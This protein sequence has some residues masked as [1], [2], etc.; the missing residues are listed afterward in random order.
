MPNTSLTSIL[1]IHGKNGKQMELAQSILESEGRKAKQCS[2]LFCNERDPGDSA[3][4]QIARL[5][6]WYTAEHPSLL[7][8]TV[9]Y[10]RSRSIELFLLE[11]EE[12]NFNDVMGILKAADVL[13][14]NERSR[15]DA[16]GKQP[17]GSRCDGGKRRGCGK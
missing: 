10:R 1:T 15:P 16:G 11:D 5:K 6:G 7:L 4:Q 13:K 14:R 17:G 3:K 9:T 8:R 12:R 2:F